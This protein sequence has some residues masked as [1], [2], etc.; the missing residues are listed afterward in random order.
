MSSAP[1]IS[2]VIPTRNR[3][4][5]LPAVL[6]GFRRQSL[7]RP[8]FEIVI[9][10]DGSE[11]ETG[12]VLASANDLPLRVFR[13]NQAG[14]AAAK[15]LG[16]L[17][18]KGP[19]VVFADDDDVPD[20]DLA[21]AHLM[22]HRRRPHDWEVILGHTALSPDVGSDPLM[23]YVAE[24]GCRLFCYRGLGSD[25]LNYQWFWGGRSSCKRSLLLT[26]GLFNPS[27]TFGC[28]DIELGWRL[29][30]RRRLDVY[31]EPTAISTMI[32]AFG[33]RQFC[34]RQMRQGRS[35]RVFARLHPSKE[36]QDYCE[37]PG[38][39]AHWRR[40]A[41]RFGQYMR[42]AERLD[43]VARVNSDRGVSIGTGAEKALHKAYAALFA[44]NRAKGLAWHGV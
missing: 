5:Y 6:D 14:I 3:A 34:A 25:R 44:L 17:A 32:R 39:P 7:D 42:W 38:G 4:I 22:A 31:Y 24:V 1:E 21:A 20:K 36:V 2:F 16:V 29:A 23:H 18:S 27:F 10:D 11:D 41:A 35:Q 37:V 40:Y 33:F 15:N 19:I 9:V 26:D 28:E 43:T 8:A 13:Q 12:A 30:S